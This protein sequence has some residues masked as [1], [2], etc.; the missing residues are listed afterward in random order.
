MVLFPWMCS[1]SFSLGYVTDRTL[2]GWSTKFA[3]WYDC[4][5]DIVPGN[6]I[7]IRDG[8]NLHVSGSHGRA[9]TTARTI[10]TVVRK[11][12]DRTVPE[13]ETD[14]ATLRYHDSHK[15]KQRSL[16]GGDRRTSFN[17][18]QMHW[19]LININHKNFPLLVTHHHCNFYSGKAVWC[20]RGAPWKW[21][22]EQAG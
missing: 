2:E 20:K 1:C 14:D 5:P 18:K 6:K 21:P 19:I 3:S 22:S 15:I 17:L 12:S 4:F 16:G 13:R 11:Y 10:T 8:A 9:Q 7:R